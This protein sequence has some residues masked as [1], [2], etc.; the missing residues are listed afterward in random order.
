M[1]DVYVAEFNIGFARFPLNDPRMSGYVEN[2][3]MVCR[4]VDAQEDLIWRPPNPDEDGHVNQVP[5]YENDLII[6]G[7]SVWKSID[8]MLRFV[9]ESDHAKFLRRRAE[10]FEDFPKN[11]QRQVIWWILSGSIPTPQEGRR[12]LE[13]LDRY[14]PTPAAFT[15]ASRFDFDPRY[16]T[17]SQ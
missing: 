12:R 3:D 5:A 13:H 17:L 14:G 4:T 2:F 6:V 11:R 9:Y 15:H 1:C 10:F 16:L 8:A 7:M